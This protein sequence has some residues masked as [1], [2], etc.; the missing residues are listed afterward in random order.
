MADLRE[1]VIAAVK[2]GFGDPA[3]RLKTQRSV[4]VQVQILPGPVERTVRNRPV[5]LRNLGSHLAAQAMPVVVDVGLRGSRESLARVESEAVTAYVDV[6]GLGAG[7][8]MLAVHAD[9]IR[10]GRRHPHRSVNGQ[11]PHLQCQRLNA[12][13]DCSGPTACAAPPAAIPSTRQ[14]CGVSARPWC[15]RCRTPAASPPR[16][17]L[18]FSSAAIRASRAD[19]SKPS[20]R[21]ARRG[22]GAVITSAG[23]VPTPAV[24]YLTR[25]VGYDAGIVISASHNPFED[26]GIK[27]FSGRGEKFTE[28][29]EREV[30][31]IVADASWTAAAGSPDGL[32][33][34]QRVDAYL[35]H[36][37]DVFP[38]AP[39]APRF[40]ARR[41][42]RERRHDRG[43]AR[44]VREPWPQH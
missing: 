9:A 2:I 8:Y 17:R 15:A 7:D 26:N 41:R 3:L 6:S 12:P 24:A 20:W 30:E 37:R 34:G 38:E 25:S 14:R 11:G 31:A 33:Q 21:T 23:V 32:R 1:S 29:V 36:L 19:G 40:Q 18:V 4:S 42:L 35:E 5:R 43:R 10:S 22:K 16:A 28:S 39:V 27:V 13:H 44:A